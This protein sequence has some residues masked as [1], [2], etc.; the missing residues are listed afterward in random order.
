MRYLLAKGEVL[1]V[2]T[3]D[4]IESVTLT[5]GEIWLTRSSDTRDYCLQAGS[6]LPA[7]RGETLIMEALTP[8]ALTI[9]CRECRAGLRITAAWPRT[10]PRTA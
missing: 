3:D 10:S 7:V 9:N 2:A 5:A 6:R 1:T 4:A 8:S